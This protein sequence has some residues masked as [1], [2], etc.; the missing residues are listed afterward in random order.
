LK[1]AKPK[2]REKRRVWLAVLAVL[3]VGGLC[4]LAY[5][6]FKSQKTASTAASKPTPAP[7]PGQPGNPGDEAKSA[8]SAQ[9]ASSPTPAPNA[10]AAIAIQLFTPESRSGGD[11]HVIS[12][13]AGATSGS[14][15][16][17]LTSPSGA[18]STFDGQIQW[19]GTYASCSFGTI[20][21]VSQ[22]GTWKA[23]LTA[24]SSGKTSGNAS[25]TFN[26]TGS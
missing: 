13:L 20:S 19:D 14:C 25:T 15:T 7:G 4:V 1:G 2:K 17:T 12:Q 22:S 21:G 9:S 6:Q 23:S 24:A 11:A 8:I 16:L 18:T 3:L 10:G 26:V 5:T